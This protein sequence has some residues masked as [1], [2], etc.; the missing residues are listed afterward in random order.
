MDGSEAGKTKDE[1]ELLYCKVVIRGQPVELF[2]KCQK[3]ANFGGVDAVCTK[4]AFDD[5]FVQGYG[6]SNERYNSLLIAVCADFAGV[7]MGRISVACT[8]MKSS[9]PW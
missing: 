2:L 3:M 6:V 5:A 7:N 4:Q 8:E 9:P 1:K